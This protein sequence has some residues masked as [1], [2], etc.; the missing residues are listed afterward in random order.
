MSDRGHRG[1]EA[2]ASAVVGPSGF[3]NFADKHAHDAIIVPADVVVP[4]RDQPNLVVPQAVILTYQRI[5]PPYL[6]DH[7]GRLAEGYPGPWRTMWLVERE[8][9][10]VIGVANAFG[11]GAP[12]AAAILEELIALGVKRFLNIGA[13]GCLQPELDFGEIVVCTGAIRDEGL[14]HHYL[15]SEKFSYPSVA[16]TQNLEAALDR[17]RLSY[18]RGLSWTIDAVYRETVAEARSYQA[19][20]TVTVEMEA[21]ALFAVAAYG[22]VELASAFVVSDH[23]LSGEGWRHA[24]GSDVLISRTLDLLEASLETL[25]QPVG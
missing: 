1:A 5:I 22:K 20:G 13:A 4:F 23:L 19:E 17:R 16:L 2:L 24:F 6:A 21:A 14:S 10:P 8:D 11:Q 12:A 7:G 3:P 25:N 9:M 15:T 18:R